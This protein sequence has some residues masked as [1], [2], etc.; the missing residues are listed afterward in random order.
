[1]FNK[2]TRRIIHFAAAAAASTN[3]AQKHLGLDISPTR[4]PFP[5]VF[6]RTPTSQ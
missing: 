3:K 6:A 2:I 1:M 5:L 4:I